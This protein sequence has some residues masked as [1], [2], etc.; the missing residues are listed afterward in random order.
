MQRIRKLFLYTLF[1]L[2]GLSTLIAGAGLL[3]LQRSLPPQ[4]GE[5]MVRGLSA[6]VTITSDRHGIPVIKAGDRADA[7]RALGY[8]TARDRLFQMDLM[9]RKNAGRL[10]ELFGQVAVDNDIRARTYGFSRVAKAVVAKL[11]PDHRRYLEAY[12]EGINSYIDNAQALPFEFTALAYRPERWKPED[13]LL[14]VLGMFDN[15]TAWAEREE[16]MLTVMEK[17]L[18]A[19]V[20]SFLTPDTD[21]FTDSLYGD[22]KPYRPVRPIPAASLETMLARHAP[23]A[24]RLAEVVQLRD[25]MAGSNAWAVSG[26]KTSD[27]RAILAND[28]HLGISVP[29]IWYRAELEDGAGRTAGV[30]LPGTPVFIAGSNGRLAWGATNLTGDFLDLVTLEI[31]P[32]NPDQYRVGDKWQHFEQTLESIRVKDN[33]PVQITVRRSIW[34]PVALEPL[35]DKPVA[36]HWSALD[37]KAVNLELLDLDQAETL[38]QAMAVVNRTGGPQLNF[39]LA[40]NQGRIG[41]TVMGQIPRRVGFDGSVSRSWA[42]GS[43]GWDGYVEAEQLPREID[44][45]S[46]WLVSANDRRIGKEYPHVIGRQFASGYRAYRITQR[47]GQMPSIN[48]WSLFALQLDTGN[49]FYDFYQQLALSAL[50]TGNAEQQPELREL[51]DTL[52]AWNGRADT[53]SLGFALLVRFRQQLAQSVFSPFLAASR[54]I[55]KNFNYAWTYID[56]PLQ[57][58]L[59]EKVPRL[60]PDPVNYRTWDDFILGQL[61]RSARQLKTAYPDTALSELTWGRSNKAQIGHPFSRA[62]P[63]LGFL[64]DMPADELAGCV[65][66]VRV[67]RSGFGA[68][69]RLVVSPAHL[70]QA[71]LHMPGGQSAHPLSPHYRDQHRYWVKGLPIGLLAGKPE[72]RLVLKPDID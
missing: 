38:E 51:R 17:S 9:R 45:P 40:D 14:V 47:L 72:H 5:F 60:L 63:L 43:A 42:D 71:L 8:V 46:G 58:M 16:R 11:P 69:E 24:V 3:F 34:G 55:D 67:T 36:V 39:L 53:D 29:N 52:L 30:T 13:S 7:L 50:S 49:E 28:M 48:E 21:R 26:A 44:P 66:C 56:T 61:K 41:W 68:S 35:L 6:P 15:L 62:V 1:T 64:L 33:E 70:D 10:A 32:D 23:D 65:T 31:N 54:N 59:T 18:P 2:L 12:A 22:A 19:D 25:L 37:D 57:A 20:V 4:D 27:G